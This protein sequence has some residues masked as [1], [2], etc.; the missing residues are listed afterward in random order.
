MRPDRSYSLKRDNRIRAAIAE[1]ERLNQ[2][3]RRFF[4]WWLS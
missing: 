1:Q 3:A 2:I 4:E